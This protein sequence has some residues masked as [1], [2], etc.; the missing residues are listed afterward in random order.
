MSYDRPNKPMY[1]FV[2]VGVLAVLAIG[3]VLFANRSPLEPGVAVAEVDVEPAVGA[4]LEAPPVAEPQA[5]EPSDELELPGNAG[6][7]APAPR[8]ETPPRTVRA[9]GETLLEGQE[10]RVRYCYDR[11]RSEF[12]DLR[13]TLA[14]SL[15]VEPNGKASQVRVKPE[16]PGVGVDQ[17]VT[18]VERQLK[19]TRYPRAQARREVD[20]YRM[21]F[22]AI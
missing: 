15:V 10:P 1:P 11:M 2:I 16:E 5:P 3:A 19:G 20:A 17:L 22:S 8:V 21:H 14:V 7:V 9:D 4:P 6:P 12:P 18:C 13:G